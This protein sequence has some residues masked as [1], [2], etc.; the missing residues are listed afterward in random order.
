MVAERLASLIPI[1]VGR[2]RSRR[3]RLFTIKDVAV[4][5]G[6]PQPVV[7]QWVP[8]TWTREGWMYTA[9]QLQCAI[10]IGRNAREGRYPSAVVDDDVAP[11]ERARRIGLV[12]DVEAAKL[13]E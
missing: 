10:E 5:C 1:G 8:R 7:A 6:L 11:A 4:A 9:E 12:D 3:A 2:W 13:D